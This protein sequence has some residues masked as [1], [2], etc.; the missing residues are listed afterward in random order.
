MPLFDGYDSDYVDAVED[1][2]HG[3]IKLLKGSGDQLVTVPWGG[4]Y[5][6][7]PG[8]AITGPAGPVGPSGTATQTDIDTVAAMAEWS[9]WINL[10]LGSDW[11]R[12]STTFAPA[13]ARYNQYS[14]QLSGLLR[15]IGPTITSGSAILVAS[16]PSALIPLYNQA[17]SIEISG[18]YQGDFRVYKTTSP[19][20]M[21]VS[22]YTDG[23]DLIQN[24]S[25]VNLDGITYAL[26]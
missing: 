26:D 20:R 4:F 8:G 1:G 22:V 25:H 17:A 3:Q 21:Y 12:W 18:S 24:S 23:P 9:P 6:Y 10:T 11:E 13:R 2:M 7:V 5:E 19:P 15:Y 14:V 16:L